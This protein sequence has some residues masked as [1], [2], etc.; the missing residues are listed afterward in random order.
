MANPGYI[1][2]NS[3]KN[4]TANF[5]LIPYQ[6]TVNAGTGGSITAPSSSPVTLNYG[7]ATPIIASPSAGNKFDGWSVTTG[8]AAI[9]SATSASTTVTLTSGNATL[10][11]NFKPL[12]QW[13]TANSGLTNKDVRALAVVSGT[14]LF[15]GTYGGGVFLSSNDGSSWTAKNGG[16][17]EF[18][19]YGTEEVVT[20]AVNGGNIFAGTFGDGV[21]LSTD[22]GSTWNYTSN[23]LTSTAIWALGING[24]GSYV[25]AGVSGYVPG[26]CFS[27]D[28]GNSWSNNHTL[29]Y[30]VDCFAV[31][32]SSIFAGTL[33][34]G[35]YSSADYG[36]TWTADTAGLGISPMIHCLAISGT[37]LFAGTEA[38]MYV[39]TNQGSTWSAHNSG[40]SSS[41]IV[42]SILV[43]GGNIFAGT[44]SGVFLSTD[45]GTTWVAVNSGL[46]IAPVYALAVCGANVYAGTSG[47]G[48]Y[49]SPL[50]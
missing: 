49:S 18:S 30:G 35:I 29:S 7:V 34:S 31:N 1:T 28:N 44:D 40:L 16:F 5:G 10:T 9:A 47:N 21:Y 2:M 32:G 8:T 24:N 22:K 25:F 11:A 20:F 17:S 48:V 45:N 37:T 33:G 23:G 50:P 26:V 42:R 27:S 36:N 15:A 13:S 4:A 39:S 19:N 6:L 41:T 46:T 43:N 38:G 14:S 12:C 3:A